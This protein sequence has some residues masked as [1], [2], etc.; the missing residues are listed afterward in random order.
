[1]PPSAVRGASLACL[2]GAVLEVTPEPVRDR[3]GVPYEATLVLRVDGHPAGRVGECCLGTLT[4]ALARLTSAADP[5]SPSAR[6]WA[7]PSCR[8]PASTLE[9]GVRRYARTA[10]LDPDAAWRTARPVLPR[11]G[12]LFALR[13][14]DPDD[15]EGG[16]ELR[17]W[18]RVEPRWV[19]GRWRIAQRAVLDAWT[20]EGR[21]VRA[22]LTAPDLAELL[23]T[24]LAGAGVPSAAL[25]PTG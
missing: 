22:V 15:P 16:A 12:E 25:R 13:H 19:D 24:V 23:R 2:D 18:L 14:R 1:M 7:D 21:A 20:D 17:C 5:A 3:D 4:E 11:D 10:G 9:E 8:F 6:R